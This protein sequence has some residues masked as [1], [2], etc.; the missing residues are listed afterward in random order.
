[1]G[2]LLTIENLTVTYGGIEA[3]KNVSLSVPEGEI[4]TLVGANG[5]GKSTVLKSA[6]GLVKPKS[7]CI[8]FKGQN[9]AAKPPHEIV[10]QG[11]ALVPEGRRVFANLTVKENLKIGAYLRKDDLKESM[12][13]IYSLFPRLKERRWQLS[14]TL[15]G[16]EQ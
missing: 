7:G 9:I 10:K 15:S 13:H 4:V 3:V 2:D 12:Q 14:G 1:M 8:F 11:I 5:A 6:A 16:G